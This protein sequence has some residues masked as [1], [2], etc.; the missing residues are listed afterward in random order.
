MNDPVV[1]ALESRV[2]RQCISL[3]HHR[4]AQKN[5]GT[6]YSS[7]HLVSAEPF[8]VVHYSEGQSYTSHYDI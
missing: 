7:Q 3:K 2:I 4:R 5:K 1:V 8:Q 6:K